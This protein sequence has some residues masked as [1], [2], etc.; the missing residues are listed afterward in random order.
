VREAVQRLRAR[1]EAELGVRATAVEVRY[2]LRY[3]G[4]SF[5]LTVRK[6]SSDPDLCEPD[7]LR[8]RF[9][10]E[11]ER[12]YGYRDERSEV[13]LVNVRV[14]ALGEAP[15]VSLAGQAQA[16]YER[17]HTRVAWAGRWLEAEL[18]RGEPPAGARIEGPALCA[19]PEST[20]LVPPGWA[21]AV[22]ELGTI[23]LERVR[24]E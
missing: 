23:A 5:E 17:G 13:E 4:Q 15:A 3:A 20:L 16:A 2:E 22:D 9:A 1:A 10:A 6:D 18:W 12:R 11:H 21:G 7:A 24:D 19:L 14:S 8:E